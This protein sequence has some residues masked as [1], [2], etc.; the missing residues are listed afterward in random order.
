MYD[1]VIALLGHFSRKM[2]YTFTQMFTVALFVITKF[3]MVSAQMSSTG[4]QENKPGY[5]RDIYTR[6]YHSGQKKNKKKKQ[7]IDAHNLNDSSGD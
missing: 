5:T 2:K 6:K 4:E 1:L 7:T 3:G